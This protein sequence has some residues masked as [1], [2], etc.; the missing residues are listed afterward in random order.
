ME[1]YEN[2]CCISAVMRPTNG[3]VVACSGSAV[4]VRDTFGVLCFEIMKSNLLSYEDL[5]TALN[6]AVLLKTVIHSLR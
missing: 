2:G 5:R 6:A 4:D 1:K 3:V